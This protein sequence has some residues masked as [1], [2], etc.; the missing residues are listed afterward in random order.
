MSD[1]RKQQ[2]DR[3]CTWC[4]TELRQDDSCPKCEPVDYTEHGQPCE[5]P[6]RKALE[7]ALSVINGELGLDWGEKYGVLFEL[8]DA[9][10]FTPCPLEAENAQLKRDTCELSAL[11][12]RTIEMQAALDHVRER[13]DQRDIDDAS[14]IRKRDNRIAALEAE[15]KRLRSEVIGTDS[16]LSAPEIVPRPNAT[17]RL[18]CTVAALEQENERLRVQLAEA[19]EIIT[20]YYNYAESAEE[21]DALASN[22]LAAAKDVRE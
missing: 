19:R 14:E 5:C 1:E 13:A 16:E 8:S 6:A 9:V 15:N 3:Y 20:S 7:E 17:D 2:P 18:L 11:R 12:T 22:W 10:F 4:N 21:A